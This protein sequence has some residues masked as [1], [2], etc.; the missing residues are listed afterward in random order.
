MKRLLLF[1]S[2]L[3]L[4][5]PLSVLAA[6]SHL[7]RLRIFDGEKAQAGVEVTV[8]YPDAERTAGTTLTLT[9]DANGFVQFKLNE[10]V[11]WVTVASLNPDVTGREFKVPNGAAETIRWDVRPREWKREA[12]P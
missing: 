5:S 3:L 11:F 6:S 10:D 8:N 4:V 9:S 7:V 1:L 2:F 12:R